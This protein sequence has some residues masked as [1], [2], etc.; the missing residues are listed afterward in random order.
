MET[1]FESV[2]GLPGKQPEPLSWSQD[3][4]LKFIDFRLRWEG[5]VNRS[6]LVEFFNISLP[7]A[8]L[9]LSK[10]TET[11]PDNLKY[12][13]KAK[14]YIRTE[15]FHPI[16]QRSAS[17]T[18]LSELLALDAGTMEAASSFVRWLPPMA[19]VPTPGRE[20]DGAVLMHLLNAIREG[21]MINVQYQTMGRENATHRIL[22][23]HAIAHD[24]QRW[25]VRAY[26]HTRNKFRDFVIARLSTVQVGG[27]SAVPVAEDQEWHTILTLVLV[28]HPALPHAS[29]RAL[30]I[31]YAMTDGRLE[32]KCRH[33]MLLYTLIRLGLM[34]ERN[35]PAV[36]QVVLFNEEEI[37][38]YL[39]MLGASLE[40]QQGRLFRGN[41]GA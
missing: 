27:Q 16:Y 19:A 17:K 41:V 30:E 40:G 5:R 33:A 14:A 9:D 12:D 20:V 39:Q 31:D 26:C 18:Y 24:G 15:Y 32:V 21:R 11:A 34:Y 2:Y 23:P 1:H 36:Q 29:R 6:D 10:Y 35:V 4:R 8:S 7:Q 38:P 22:S 37:E 28:P 3:G 25:H 13:P